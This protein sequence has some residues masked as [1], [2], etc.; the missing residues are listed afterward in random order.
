MKVLPCLKC[1]IIAASGMDNIDLD[2]ASDY[3][4]KVK[5][6]VGYA[7]FSVAYHT[8]AMYFH[9]NQPLNKEKKYVQESRWERHHSFSLYDHFQ[10]LSGQVW[11]IIGLGKI[12]E[13][14]AQTVESL[15]A[16]VIYYSSTNTVR[17]SI[18]EKVNFSEL[19]FRSHVISIHS[20]LTQKTKGLIGQKELEKL[21][22][23][24]TLLNLGRGE[25]IN[26]EELAVFLKSSHL[27]VGL[28]VTESEPLQKTAAITE[29]LSREQLIVT[30][31]MAWA[32]DQSRLR[33]VESIKAN[34]RDFIIFNQNS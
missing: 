34:I 20:S 14:V 16:K 23:C 3:G 32:S 5:N 2:A 27:K 31:H 30:P 22:N 21:K 8:L 19:L 25:I 24:H 12:G 29:L 26:E 17:S 4:I 18:Y 33:L 9:L 13:R 28:D 7:D 1:I 11:G 15:G 6:S 10:D